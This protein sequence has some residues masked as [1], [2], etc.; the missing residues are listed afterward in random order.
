MS[1]KEIAEILYEIADIL[2]IQS[3]QWKPRAYRIAAQ[4]IENLS[5]DLNS[6][7][8]K[9]GIKF[10]EQI[11][12][13][14]KGIAKKI[15]EFIKTGKIKEYESMKRKLPTGLLKLLD[16][17]SLGPKKV[18]FLYKKLRIK[19][20]AELE[21]YLKRHTLN[22][23][24]LKEKTRENI[25]HG[26]EIVKQGKGRYSIG[27]AYP[28]AQEI[29]THL[30]KTKPLKIDLAGSLRRMK[31]TVHDIDIVVVPS[32]KDTISSF[33]SL[34]RKISHGE[35]KSSIIYEGIQAD[36]R[37]FNND[38]YG[39][40]LQY[41]TGSKNHNIKLRE[42]AIKKGFKLNE[43]G[44]FKNNKKT[45]GP[46]ESEIYKKLSLPFIP[47]ELRENEFEFTEKIPSLIEYNDIKGDLHV[48][49]EYS[50]GENTLKE[51][52]IAGKSSNHYLAVTDHGSSLGILDSLSQ[53]M[54]YKKSVE[55]KKY[56]N[57]LFG[58]E[59]DILNDGKLFYN[60]SVLKQ[61]D[62]VLAAIHSGFSKDNTNRILKAMDNRYLNVLA[63]LTG[64]KFNIKDSM[65]MDYEKIFDK[66]VDNSI[67]I[68]INCNSQRMDIDY[69]LIHD[70]VKRGGKLIIGT[71]SH[72]LNQL[73]NIYFG[74]GLARRGWC[75]KSDV[76]NA[77]SLEKLKFRLNKH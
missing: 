25:L 21:S 29:I 3:I 16:V 47:P 72:S 31:S 7:Y 65:K 13:I 27:E 41:F 30:K 44:L 48:H 71:D 28:L 73:N 32:G 67:A 55:I 8:K 64:R 26:I 46:D 68:E 45:A 50:D 37:V 62:I 11:P 60:D 34:G 43:Y 23:P 77:L 22:I 18:M 15:E 1:N 58:A 59:V 36:L 20:P 40:A 61:F 76:L 75:K 69:S 38:E 2:E 51:L 42:I 24:G 49:S 70:F 19:S 39:A 10:L 53:K 4:N 66:A 74:V 33:L 63:H 12:G 56:P 35:K 54:L 14:G 5:E 9:Q 17:P 6:V 57:L 52:S